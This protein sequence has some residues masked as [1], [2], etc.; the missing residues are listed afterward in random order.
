MNGN[1]GGVGNVPYF[2][3]L[4]EAIVGD[5]VGVGFVDGG[6]QDAMTIRGG[7]EVIVIGGL[8]EGSDREGGGVDESELGKGEVIEKVLVAGGAKSIACFVGAALPF[9]AGSFLNAGTREDF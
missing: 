2:D 6:Y 8:A 7:I 3:L 4:G 5:D 1:A 9:L